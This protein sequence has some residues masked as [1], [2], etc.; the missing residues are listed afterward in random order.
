MS[1]VFYHTAFLLPGNTHTEFQAVAIFLVI[2]GFTT[3]QT[4]A[5]NP[6]SFFYRRVIRIVPLYW[7]ATLYRV[8]WFTLK[9]TKLIGMIIGM[10]LVYLAGKYYAKSGGKYVSTITDKRHLLLRCLMALFIVTSVCLWMS[11]AHESFFNFL[12]KSLFFIRALDRNGD[13]HPVL[14]VGWILNLQMFFYVIYA[15]SLFAG[16]RLAPILTCLVLITIKALYLTG[17]CTNNYFKFYSHGYSMFIILGIIL[18]YA[19]IY[20]K[21]K[22]I[23]RK[24]SI[25][26]LLTATAYVFLTNLALINVSSFFRG[27]ID[28]YIGYY[29]GPTI[30]VGAAL[31][32]HSAG[33]QCK[34]SFAIIL[35]DAS[36]SL[37]LLHTMIIGALRPLI[38]IWPVLDFSRNIFGLFVSMS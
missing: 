26:L 10:V 9:P 4:A 31:L 35:G 11:I 5:N 7:I 15:V 33:I 18:H 36:Y 27:P 3:S 24:L 8:F 19:F 21:D 13:F 6:I 30:L 16:K 23:S 1:I 34:W 20:S 2:S 32:C 29:M 22:V 17:I 28:G 12:L 14:S 25:T 38:V 37:Y